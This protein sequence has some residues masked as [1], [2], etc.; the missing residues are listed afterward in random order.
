MLK[1]NK[2]DSIVFSFATIEEAMEASKA[3]D[4]L[5]V[6]NQFYGDQMH[7][8]ISASDQNA[9]LAVLEDALDYHDFGVYSVDNVIGEV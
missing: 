7:V 6:E 2:K 4:V 9:A 3:L 8:T 1:S 5:N